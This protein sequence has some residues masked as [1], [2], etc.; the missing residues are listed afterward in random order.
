[1]FALC[2][3]LSLHEPVYLLSLD[4]DA[5]SQAIRVVAN[6]SG[7]PLSSIEGQADEWAAWLGK[8]RSAWLRWGFSGGLAELDKR[9]EAEVEFW[10]VPPSLVIVDNVSN[11]VT[12]ESAQ[13]Y[14][15]AYADLHAMAR[16]FET[17]VVG[18]THVRRG[19]GGDGTQPVTMASSRYAGEAEAEVVLGLWRQQPHELTVG[20]LKNRMGPADPHGHRTV[21]LAFDVERA[22]VRDC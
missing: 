22:Q 7:T 1:M 13:G 15:S 21:K 19:N 8:Q 2:W 6:L 3:A 18:L 16:D 14:W 10:G 17:V 4:T 5:R 12:E 11:V 9:L 20:I